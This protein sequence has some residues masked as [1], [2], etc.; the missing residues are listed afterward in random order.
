[1]RGCMIF[2]LNSNAEG[3]AIVQWHVCPRKEGRKV[4]TELMAN[5]LQVELRQAGGGG[6]V[7]PCSEFARGR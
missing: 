6:G 1:M 5:K 2:V 7:S 4:L 3:M